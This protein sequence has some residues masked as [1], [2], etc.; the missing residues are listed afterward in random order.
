MKKVIIAFSSDSI[1]AREFMTGTI[2][3]A[4]KKPDWHIRILDSTRSISPQMVNHMIAEKVDGVL[5]G[6]SDSSPGYEALI[7]SEIPIALNNFPSQ[8]PPPP[9]PSI[10]LLH[11]DDVEI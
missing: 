3:Y 6:F 2:L 9:S 5:T 7:K 10:I 11:N 1:A 4:N 8:N